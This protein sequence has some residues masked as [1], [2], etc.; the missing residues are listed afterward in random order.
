MPR[1]KDPGLPFILRENDSHSLSFPS[2]D[3]LPDPA[4]GVEFGP[5]DYRKGSLF[6]QLPIQHIKRRPRLTL[7]SGSTWQ[8][9]NHPSGVRTI[10]CQPHN[11]SQGKSLQG[12]TVRNWVSK[13]QTS[14][15]CSMKPEMGA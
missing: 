15:P 6:I 7:L 5:T 3:V 4:R 14:H 8:M 11:P 9:W 1:M 2:Y 10:P 12:V 13:R